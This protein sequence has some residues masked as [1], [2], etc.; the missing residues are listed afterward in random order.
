MTGTLLGMLSSCGG[1]VVA[2]DGSW[3]ECPRANEVASVKV[4][5]HATPFG[6][7]G[8]IRGLIASSRDGR[9]ARNLF[10]AAC[11]LVAV[12]AHPPR[13]SVI[14]CPEDF[15]VVYVAVFHDRQNRE[16]ATATY[17]A[18]GCQSLKMQVPPR[19]ELS[20]LVIGEKAPA[21]AV[22]FVA[23]LA[24]TIGVP[25]SGISGPFR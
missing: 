14:S 11:R 24:A 19:A 16:L 8:G 9:Q 3:Q 22:P 18:T 2:P 5:R 4:T 20:T 25:Q 15:G 21:L 1:P 7:P 6:P 12:N 13:G 23:A 10:V 17:L